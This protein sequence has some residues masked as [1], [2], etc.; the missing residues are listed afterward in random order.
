MGSKRRRKTRQLDDFDEV[1]EEGE[2]G[3]GARRHEID[4]HGCTIEA[5]ERRLAQELARCRAGGVSNV[6]VVTGKGHGSFAGRARLG[7]AV[8]R[9]LRGAEGKAHGVTQARWLRRGGAL[10]VSISK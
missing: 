9:W 8:E 4:L 5:A 1:G 10:E 6:L 2:S 3:R 7:P